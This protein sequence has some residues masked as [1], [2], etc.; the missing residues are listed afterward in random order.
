MQAF[1]VHRP[2][3]LRTDLRRTGDGQGTMLVWD[4]PLRGGWT[5]RV[6]DELSLFDVPQASRRSVLYLRSRAARAFSVGVG[7][8]LDRAVRDTFRW[9]ARVLPCLRLDHASHA[10]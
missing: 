6:N 9:L 10:G 3:R 2:H 7:R 5:L 8:R 4:G 1:A